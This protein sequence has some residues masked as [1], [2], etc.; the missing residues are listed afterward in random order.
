MSSTTT[1]PLSPQ[2]FYQQEAR[3]QVDS[4]QRSQLGGLA[5]ENQVRYQVEKQYLRQDPSGQGDLYQLTVLSRTHTSTHPLHRI[6]A[7]LA[8]LQSKL[9]LCIDQTGRPIRLDNQPAIQSAWKGMRRLFTK[10]YRKEV[11]ALEKIMA[12]IEETASNEQALLKAFLSS[13][14]ACLL[15][16]ILYGELEAVQARREVKVFAHFIGSA[17]LPLQV[18]VSD[19]RH[20][21]VADKHHFKRSG[22]VDEEAYP[23]D[24]VRQFFTT[25]ASQGPIRT[26]LQVDYQ[27]LFTLNEHH[28]L[29]HSG[30]VMNAHIKGLFRYNQVVKFKPLLVT[31]AAE[32]IPPQPARR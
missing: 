10:R 12:G 14:L 13:D 16:P 25:L 18:R 28:W 3:Y 20:D 26:S 24:E 8:A 1:A 15:F 21:R 30:Q 7:D 27:E 31:T 2:L 17:S 9:V 22:V 4:L 29:T 19:Y 5:S 32:P 11:P 6:E 23:E